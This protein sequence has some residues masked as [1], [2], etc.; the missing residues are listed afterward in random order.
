MNSRLLLAALL[1]TTIAAGA[2][3]TLPL[4]PL[5]PNF[6]LMGNGGPLALPGA[7]EMG[8]DSAR[9]PGSEQVYSI[10]CQNSALPSFGGA[11]YTIQTTRYQG[12]RVRVS[13]SLSASGIADVSTP[14]YPGVKGE[15][16]LWVS[17]GS[18]RNGARSDRMADRTIAGTTDWLTRDFVVDVPDDSFQIAV[19]FW[20]QGRGQM[21]VRDFKVEEVPTSV[22]VNFLLQDP[23][24]DVGPD[25]SLLAP[26]AAQ[27]DFGFLPP[28]PKWLAIGGQGFELCDIGVDAR[29]L[30]GG[31]RNLS[32][33][34]SFP[35]TPALRQSIDGAPW[36][37]KRVRFSAWVRSQDF[38]PLPTDGGPGGAGL[39]IS[40][41]SNTGTTLHAN[42]TGTTDW[43][44]RELV[45][46]VQRGTPWILMGLAMS[47]SGQ[48]WARDFKFEEV[49]MD[50]PVTTTSEVLR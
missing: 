33:A 40:N 27:S 29:M 3:E 28:P 25:L 7:C 4:A 47:G 26:A 2:Q 20:M 11:R 39:W 18:Q 43:T 35:Q 42:V 36:W 13:A 10:R 45:M 46:D 30:Q 22:P 49:S 32:I 8:I 9:A 48:V 6:S 50:V 12:K 19:G 16:G 41:S 23:Q 24:R 31:Q 15:A 34:C 1:A 17:V 37:G 38:D 5:P 21:W 44:Y 14:Q